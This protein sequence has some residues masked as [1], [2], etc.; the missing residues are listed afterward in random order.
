MS[1]NQLSMLKSRLTELDKT[2]NT[3]RKELLLWLQKQEKNPA[4]DEEDMVENP[5]QAAAHKTSFVL[6]GFVSDFISKTRI[7]S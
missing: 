5:T 3:H 6:Q 2:V 1:L 7:S 4:E